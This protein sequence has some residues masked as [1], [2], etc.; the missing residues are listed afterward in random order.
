MTDIR[1]PWYPQNF[2]NLTIIFP[3]V[4]MSEGKT[5]RS[6][7]RIR[8]A[9]S[10]KRDVK[11]LPGLSRTST[12]LSRAPPQDINEIKIKLVQMEEEIRQ[13]KAKT[14]RMK[15]VVSDRNASIKQ[16][17]NTKNERQVLT[18]ASDSTIRQLEMNVES[19]RNA[20]EAR[21]IELDKLRGSDNLYVSEEYQIEI[22]VFY[23]EYQ[24]LLEQNKAVQESLRI[25]ENELEKLHQ[26]IINSDKHQKNIQTVQSDIDTIIDKILAYKKSEFKINRT[27]LYQEIGGIKANIPIKEKQLQEE[28]ESLKIDIENE[29]EKLDTIRENDEKNMEFLQGIIEDQI[30]QIIEATKNLDENESSNESAN[31]SFV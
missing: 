24:R 10:T 30:R 20:L 3:N 28:I 2:R 27:T 1:S 4:H 19:V 29:K 13:M 5:P 15:Q 11:P 23:L 26:Q 9:M 18:T 14:A 22:K 8:T 25:I 31:S 12:S 17:L 16:A 6:P 7:I 21:S